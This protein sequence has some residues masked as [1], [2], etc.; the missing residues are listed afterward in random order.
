MRLVLE[1]K[2]CSVCEATEG[3]ETIPATGK[4]KYTEFMD[5]NSNNAKEPT[6]DEDG[7]ARFRCATCTK[8]SLKTVEKLGH[9]DVE[10]ILREA[11][12]TKNGWKEITCSREGCGKCITQIIEATGHTPE[13]VPAVPASCTATG[14]SEGVKCSV[15]E[16]ILTPQV[17]TPKVDHEYTIEVPGEEVTC[18]KDGY[19]AHKKCAN[20]DATQGK[21]EIDTDGHIFE[22]YICKVCGVRDGSCE[23]ENAVIKYTAPKC[24]D[25]GSQSF[26]CPECNY[27]KIEIL[28]QLDHQKVD[29]SVAGTC[30]TMGREHVICTLCN[31]DLVNKETG[32]GPHNIV[33]GKCTVCGTIECAHSNT[34]T[35]TDP[36]TCTQNGSQ[37]VICDVCGTILSTKTLPAT[38]HSHVNG[39]CSVCG[40]KDSNRITTDFQDIFVVG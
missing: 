31:Q 2:Q 5:Y 1:T 29:K 17:V 21:E 19:T 38:G 39:I 24:T 37:S 10:D 36:A 28:P 22:N 23:H 25:A 7:K 27:E 20:C 35:H 30:I 11:T 33:N 12:C 16:E 8:W 6:C 34:T 3:Y 9:I 13:A 40:H 32:Y 26:W 15:C 18:T 14:L 4:H